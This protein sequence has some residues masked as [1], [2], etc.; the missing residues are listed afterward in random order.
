MLLCMTFRIIDES[1]STVS[2]KWPEVTTAF[3][4]IIWTRQTHLR[5]IAPMR[6]SLIGWDMIK[7]ERVFV[8]G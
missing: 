8:E 1:V 3:V 6:Y 5:P 7:I 2:Y 4:G